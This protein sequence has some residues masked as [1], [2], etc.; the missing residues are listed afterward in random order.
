[1]YRP[2][3]IETENEN[4]ETFVKEKKEFEGL[5]LNETQEKGDQN[6]TLYLEQA[7]ETGNQNETLKKEGKLH[8]TFDGN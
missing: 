1:M 7:Q 8:E 4:E 2:K 6:E 5:D 3:E